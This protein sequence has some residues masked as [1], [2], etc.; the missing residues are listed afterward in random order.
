MFC[1]VCFCRGKGSRKGHMFIDKELNQREGRMYKD[2]FPRD[3]SG[4]TG[5]EARRRKTSHRDRCSPL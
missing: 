3:F 2:P 1:F 4:V 5:K